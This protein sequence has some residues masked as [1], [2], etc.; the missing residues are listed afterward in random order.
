MLPSPRDPTTTRSTCKLVGK[1]RRQRQYAT[2]FQGARSSTRSFKTSYKTA[3]LTH[4][5]S[6]NPPPSW[7]SKDCQVKKAFCLQGL[8]CRSHHGG[9]KMIALHIR[10]TNNGVFAMSQ[11]ACLA[12]AYCARMGPGP[13][14]LASI[15]SC[16]LTLICNRRTA[17]QPRQVHKRKRQVRLDW[18]DWF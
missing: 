9:R 2:G 4:R 16:I 15:K 17:T 11:R 6:A 8:V 7:G 13:S 5:D 18:I 12:S 3:H 14:L 1:N 10:D